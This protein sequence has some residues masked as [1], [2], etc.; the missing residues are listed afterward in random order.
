ME[1]R[2]AKTP[3][4]AAAGRSGSLTGTQFQDLIGTIT[5]GSSYEEGD[6]ENEGGMDAT[7]AAA[8]GVALP[9]GPGGVVMATTGDTLLRHRL[10]F[11]RRGEDGLDDG[12]TQYR[13]ARG[14]GGQYCLFRRIADPERCHLRSHFC[15][16][17]EGGDGL[18]LGE[19]ENIQQFARSE[20]EHQQGG[21]KHHGKRGA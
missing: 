18:H 11:D 3:V 2:L 7:A 15:K 16:Q 21:K 8:G 9:M 13:W 20:A 6:E 17:I 1:M 14:Q 5:G 4:M 10:S 12:I 19:F